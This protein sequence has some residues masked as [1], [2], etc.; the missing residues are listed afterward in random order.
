MGSLVLSR[1]TSYFSNRVQ[2]VNVA[3]C[4]SQPHAMTSGI[5]QGGLH[6]FIPFLIYIYGVFSVIRRGIPNSFARCMK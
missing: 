6:G 1:L 2:F 3:G 5:V 4:F